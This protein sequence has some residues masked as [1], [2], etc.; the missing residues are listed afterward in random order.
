MAAIVRLGV[1][2]ET[3]ILKALDIGADGVLVAHVESVADAARVASLARYHPRGVRGFSPFTRAGGYSGGDISRHAETQ[4]A[5]TLV[6]VILEGESGV[7]AV[8]D[9]VREVDIDLIYIG[10]YDLSQALGMPGQVT[11]PE[12]RKEMERCAG[13][14]RQSGC[15]S[16]GY[17]ARSGEDIAW[18]KQIGLQFI[19]WMPDCVMFHEA[20]RSAVT[21][22]NETVA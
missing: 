2:S 16:G 21:L 19:S 15:A 8:E 1:I 4:N 14:I 5:R 11:H 9:I 6:G 3:D 17:V 20:C 22:Y 18:M 12:V 13:I 10:A 7:A